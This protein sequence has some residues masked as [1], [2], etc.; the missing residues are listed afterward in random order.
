MCVYMYIYVC[1]YIY[2][3]RSV[4]VPLVSSMDNGVCMPHS[5][6]E[7]CLNEHCMYKMM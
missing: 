1:M 4:Y 6:Q 5:A 2:M 3:Y 7:G